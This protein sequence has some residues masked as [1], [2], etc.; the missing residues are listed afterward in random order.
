MK[1]GLSIAAV[2]F[3]LDQLSKWAVQNLFSGSFD[4]WSLGTFFNLVEAW[5]TGISFSLFSNNGVLGTVLLI[6]V[7]LIVVIVLLYWLSKEKLSLMQT[8]LGLIIGGALGNII[9][10]VRFGA[11]YDFLDFYYAKWHWPAFNLADSF[12]CIG[13]ALILFNSLINARKKETKE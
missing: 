4:G 2:A 5:N 1:L 10:R 6:G 7:A 8:A 12:I 11:V 13:A 3:V 9:D